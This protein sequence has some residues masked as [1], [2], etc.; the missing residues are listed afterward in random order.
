MKNKRFIISVILVIIVLFIIIATSILFIDKQE[1]IGVVKGATS[2]I[3]VYYY[4]SG[5]DRAYEIEEGDS[6]QSANL[7][8]SSGKIVEVKKNQ[9]TIEFVDKK[10]LE[11]GEY[12]VTVELGEEVLT[13]KFKVDNT[14]P[15][16]SGLEKS[17]HKEDVTITFDNIEDVTVATLELP[18]GETIDL[19]GLY[20]K[21]KLKQNEYGKSIY[22]IEYN[23]KSQGTYIF[24]TRD[25]ANNLYRK[26]FEVM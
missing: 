16:I 1:N 8:I 15:I 5:S 14:A 20:Q 26:K 21:G 7:C 12:S 9:E 25:A 13:R 11:E 4:M 10:P 3:Q 23:Q 19:Y 22:V 24:T 6:I 17:I 18:Q 2:K